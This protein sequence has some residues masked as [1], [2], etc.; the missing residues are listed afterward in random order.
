[1]STNAAQAAAFYRE[2]L[3]EGL[4][5]GVRDDDGF[6]APLSTNGERAMPFWSLRSRAERII[7]NVP[8]YADFDVVSLDLAVWRRHW[9]TGLE[10]DN[11]L[12]GL[13]WSG[14]RASGYDVPGSTVEH[15]LTALGAPRLPT[16]L[17][18][19]LRTLPRLWRPQGHHT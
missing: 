16:P 17:P 8:A 1:M 10:A 3:R 12:V 18:R 5:W 19:R 6:P 4:V 11:V 14:I 9:L 13:N 2:I 15:N 7:A